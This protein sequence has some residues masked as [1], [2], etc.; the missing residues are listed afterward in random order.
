VD[1]RRPGAD[2]ARTVNAAIQLARPALAI[3]ALTSLPR[4]FSL[5]A[6]RRCS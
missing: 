4:L 1:R 2:D 5:L 3:V 6:A